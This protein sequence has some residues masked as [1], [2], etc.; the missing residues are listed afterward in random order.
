MRNLICISLITF[1]TTFIV[2][3]ML[4]N[5]VPIDKK[6]L[7]YIQAGQS[8]KTIY[9]DLYKHN[10]IKD[11]LAF[12]LY[13]K[14]TGSTLKTGEFSY[15]ISDSPSDLLHKIDTNDYY[16]RSITI[17]EGLSVMQ[18]TYLLHDNSYLSGDLII[19][20]ADMLMPETYNFVRGDKRL[21]LYNNMKQ[22]FQKMAVP[23][24]KNRDERL[25]FKTFLQAVTLASI[26][27]KETGLD[28]ERKK[29]ASVFINRLRKGIPLQSDSTT[30]YALSEGLGKLDRRLT[31]K[32]WKF[33]HPFNTYY[34]Q[35]MP[36]H[37][38]AGVG[39]KSLK[40]VLNPIKSGY[41]YF[42]ATGLGG[43]YFSKTLAEHNKNY[44]QY[45]KN[46]NK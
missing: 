27:E 4:A 9:A 7:T 2:F 21:A 31:R 26:V 30:I 40:A 10:V 16:Y 5:S 11:T 12:S 44:Q 1:L 13:R 33:K 29:V 37:P 20:P 41:Y 6:G 42:V 3:I 18:V 34:I 22:S 43:H 32:D 15:D 35:G 36:P 28:G 23:I 46:L 25:P 45:K 8:A 38:I 19:N 39:L 17:P 24:W 14:F